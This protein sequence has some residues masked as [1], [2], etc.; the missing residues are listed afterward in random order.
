MKKIIKNNK[1]LIIITITILIFIILL[2]IKYHNNKTLKNIN[3]SYN[4]YIIIKKDT[5][6]YN[7]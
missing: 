7:S 2:L 1:I 4:K 3:K 6:I 5:N